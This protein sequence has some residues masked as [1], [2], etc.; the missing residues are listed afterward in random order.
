MLE[1]KIVEI[2]TETN[3]CK[4]F[5]FYTESKI[6]YEAGQFLTFL[7]DINGKEVRRSYSLSSS[8]QVDELLSITIKQVS[9]GEISRWWLQKAKVGDILKALPPAGVF[10][11]KWQ[12][13]PRDIF[14]AGAGSGIIPLYSIL[15]SALIK[16]PQ[17][18][19]VLLYSNSSKSTTIF[20]DQLQALEKIYPGQLSIVWLFSDN[21]DLSYARLSTY[22]LQRILEGSLVYRPGNAVMYTCGP[23]RYMQTVQITW[24]TM[25]FSKNN[26]RRELFEINELPESTKRYFDKTDRLVTINFNGDSVS[27]LVRYFE[28]ILGAALKSGIN[29]PY[30]CKAGKCS[31]C[32]CTVI[33]GT[34]WMHY[35]EVLTDE[36]EAKGYALTCTGHP[37][38]PNVVIDIA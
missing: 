35:N 1:L 7:F 37:I 31:T 17:S 9:N 27:I 25:G 24:L 23:F 22:N 30:S 21:Q 12:L 19:I 11:L 26:F 3:A 20:L 29:L 38:S 4:T 36:D 32:K 28:T 8:P 16:E 18:H 13:Q 15:K 5:S 6:A 33:S 2:H 10:S 34:V 14:L